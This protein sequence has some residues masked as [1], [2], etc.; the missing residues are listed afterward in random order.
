MLKHHNILKIFTLR[1]FVLVAHILGQ[2]LKLTQASNDLDLFVFTTR[3]W[4]WGKIMFSLVSVCHSV[5]RGCI[6]T[7]THNASG[8]GYPLPKTWDLGTYSPPFLLTSGEHHWRHG[9]YPNPPDI[10][11][12]LPKHV[13][14]TIGRYAFYG[15]AFLL[16]LIPGRMHIKMIYIMHHA[17]GGICYWIIFA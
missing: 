5:L 2:R 16:P 3:K 1:T 17:A 6:V 14:L 13:R 12:L 10:W 7:I 11:W 8:H 9:T 4:S 15:N